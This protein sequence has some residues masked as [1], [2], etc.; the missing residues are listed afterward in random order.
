MTQKYICHNL[1]QFLLKSCPTRLPYL[2][3]GFS[4]LSEYNFLEFQLY[5]MILVLCLKFG[6]PVN[7][8]VK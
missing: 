6:N 3:Q 4:G 8:N 1:G 2:D 7:I 5:T